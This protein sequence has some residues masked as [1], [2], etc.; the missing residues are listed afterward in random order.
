MRHSLIF[1]VK[2]NILFPLRLDISCKGKYSLPI[3]T[4]KKWE[5]R[6]C[7]LVAFNS[8]AY[9][10][11]SAA[12]ECLHQESI[13]VHALSKLLEAV[14]KSIKHATALFTILAIELL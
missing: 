8:H 4:I 2:E 6:A 14:A 7:N 5:Q 11:S 12:Y 13:S 9:L 3:K 1:L 10:I